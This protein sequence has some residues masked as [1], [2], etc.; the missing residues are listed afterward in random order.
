MKTPVTMVDGRKPDKA[1]RQQV[2][3]IRTQYNAA[4]GAI[5]LLKLCGVDE[6]TAIKSAAKH[7]NI[8]ARS[9][10]LAYVLRDNK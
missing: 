7:R 8:N 3:A 1:Y 2:L 4:H 9:L 5:D 10:A 6:S